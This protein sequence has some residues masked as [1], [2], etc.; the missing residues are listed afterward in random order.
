[1]LRTIPSRCALLGASH[2]MA[3]APGAP[4][5]WPS[6]RCPHLASYQVCLQVN[7][8]SFLTVGEIFDVW[9]TDVNGRFN[10]IM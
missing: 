10:A 3:A 5:S 6:T 2:K 9:F 1:M 4:R 8:P 7:N